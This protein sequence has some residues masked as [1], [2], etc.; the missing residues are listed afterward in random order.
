MPKALRN[1]GSW[2]YYLR[3]SIFFPLHCS[4]KKLTK[5]TAAPSVLFIKYTVQLCVGG[6]TQGRGGGVGLPGWE[7]H[8]TVALWVFVIGTAC[9]VGLR[10]HSQLLG[11][12]AAMQPEWIP[13]EQPWPH[14][15]DASHVQAHKCG[16]QIPAQRNN[17]LLF[18]FFSFF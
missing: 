6:G 2:I 7:T 10:G 5:K 16:R 1:S 15:Q 3:W 8:V 18:F 4:S 13:P 17:K 12:I 14:K 11:R 9:L